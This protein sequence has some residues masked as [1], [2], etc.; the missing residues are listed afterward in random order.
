MLVIAKDQ[1]IIETFVKII[2]TLRVVG[3]FIQQNKTN[4]RSRTY[5]WIHKSPTKKERVREREQETFLYSFK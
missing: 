3:C 2:I 4:G 1:K 5:N